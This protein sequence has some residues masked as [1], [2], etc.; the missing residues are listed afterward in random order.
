MDR[1]LSVGDNLE[2]FLPETAPR[3]PFVLAPEQMR[4]R[5]LD[6]VPQPWA[7]E[8]KSTTAGKVTW[9][10]G[11]MLSNFPIAVFDR[12]DAQPGRSPT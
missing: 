10:D 12:T 4:T 11:G 1:P 2:L 7:R 3:G 8:R 6:L 5:Y 9:V